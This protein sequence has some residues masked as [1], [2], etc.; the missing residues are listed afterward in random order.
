MLLINANITKILDNWCCFYA[1][2]CSIWV[3]II[4]FF[5]SV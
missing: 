1:K 3:F 4:F 5:F 2:C